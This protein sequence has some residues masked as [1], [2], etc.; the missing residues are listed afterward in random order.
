MFWTI[1]G[2]LEKNTDVS[3]TQVVGDFSKTQYGWVLSSS[4]ATHISDAQI[5]ETLKAN[6]DAGVKYALGLLA[7]T[8]GDFMTSAG[9]DEASIAS[10]YKIAAGRVIQITANALGY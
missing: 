1:G 2:K 10:L 4:L 7:A 9:F 3:V 8:P 6:L 5:V